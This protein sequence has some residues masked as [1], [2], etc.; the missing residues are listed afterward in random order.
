MVL[1]IFTSCEP[2]N[3]EQQKIDLE[4]FSQSVSETD[5]ISETLQAEL[6]LSTSTEETSD[7]EETVETAETTESEETT[8]STNSQT[9]ESVPTPTNNNPTEET[10]TPTESNKPVVNPL[11][12]Y[13]NNSYNAL[14]YT[15]QKAMWFTFFDYANIL[16][17]KSQ[18]QFKA[19]ITKEFTNA[20]NMGINTVYV[21]VRSHSDAYYKSDIFPWGV[22]CT[23][24]IGSGPSYDPLKVMIESAHSLGLSF[25]A[26]INPM[27]GMTTSEMDSL[28]SK[29][30]TKKWYNDEN[31]RGNYIVEVGGRWYLNP[32]YS[33][34]RELISAG[35]EEIVSKY[36][37]DGIHIDDYFYPTTQ[38]EFDSGAFAISGSS[39]LASWR[40]SN[41]SS[42]VKGMYNAVKSKNKTVLF[43]ISPQGSIDINENVQY[44][45]VKLWSRQSGYCDYIAPQ[46]YYGYKNQSCPFDDMLN[47][48]T[49][50][51]NSSQ[52]DLIIGVCTYK[53]GLVDQWA[54]SGKNEWVDDKNVPSRQIQDAL[55][56]NVD[57]VAIYSYSST[58]S[59]PSSVSDLI[60]LE[61][62]EIEKAL[63]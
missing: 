32:A 44:A 2:I 4:N 45:D 39:N 16:Q 37:V 30:T 26:W 14:N 28:S 19:N 1:V 46:I 62:I 12:D 15:T 24:K 42:M 13:G 18:S 48:W 55:D 20:K 52:I 21:H 31:F 23:G 47:D 10:P 54:G 53:L 38:S 51:A 29:Y 22:Y 9:E 11:P 60:E 49:A 8:E 34:V 6:P 17:N 40:R 36:N 27:R 61:I 63:S 50:L 3:V 33:E 56:A 59:P 58:F 57:G 5:E 35:V 25:H 41:A 43:G 7:T